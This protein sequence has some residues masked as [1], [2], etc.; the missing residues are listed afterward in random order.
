MYKHVWQQTTEYDW[1]TDSSEVKFYK[2]VELYGIS[3]S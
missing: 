2:G 1:R 3:L